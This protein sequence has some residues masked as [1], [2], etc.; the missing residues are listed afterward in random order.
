MNSLRDGFVPLREKDV[1]ER[2][3]SPWVRS[4]TPRENDTDKFKECSSRKR[5]FS[6][7]GKLTP[8]NDKVVGKVTV[9]SRKRI[10]NRFPR[11]GSRDRVVPLR[12]RIFLLKDRITPPKGRFFSLGEKIVNNLTF[13]RKK[14]G[15][16]HV[17]PVKPVF[18]RG[19]PISLM[20]K[21]MSPKDKFTSPKRNGGKETCFFQGRGM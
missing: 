20:Y 4:T 13:P 6:P 2:D 15:E 7:R 19:G 17:S 18:P 21:M 14:V 8:P 5:A 11:R 16:G 12:K 9:F 10:K 1:V 3:T